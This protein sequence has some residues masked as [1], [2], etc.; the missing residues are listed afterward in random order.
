MCGSFTGRRVPIDGQLGG[1]VRRWRVPMSRP[2]KRIRLLQRGDGWGVLAHIED[3]KLRVYPTR[4]Q[5]EDVCARLMAADGD[6]WREIEL[7]ALW[8]S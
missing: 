1:E 3:A 4:A 8:W 2:P 7:P 6:T 5:A